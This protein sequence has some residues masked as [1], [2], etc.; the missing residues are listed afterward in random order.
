MAADGERTSNTFARGNSTLLGAVRQLWPTPDASR[1]NETESLETFEARQAALK[2][3]GKNGNGCGTP[4]GVAV[5]QEWPTPTV[6][7]NHNRKGASPE[8]GDGLATAVQER[9]LWATAL[10][11]DCAKQPTNG[12]ERQVRTGSNHGRMGASDPCGLRL[13]PDWVE[14]LMGFPSGWTAGVPAVAK[15][16]TRRSRRAPLPA[17]GETE[18]PSG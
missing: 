6:S 13:N 18:P 4:L 16:S 3:Q 12:L 1:A 8:S 5:R 7:G 9:Q 11:T 17:G 15:S 10:A 14:L 2:A